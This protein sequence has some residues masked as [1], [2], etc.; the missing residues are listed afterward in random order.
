MMWNPAV[1]GMRSPRTASATARSRTRFRRFWMVLFFLCTKSAIARTD[2]L[3]GSRRC[4][5]VYRYPSS[6][7]VR[8]S[9]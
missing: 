9:R 7:G 4:R 6:K 3:D 8:F 1:G 5:W 2:H